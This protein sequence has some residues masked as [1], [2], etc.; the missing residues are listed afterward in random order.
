MSA[1]ISGQV[2]S[3]ALV[4]DAKCD[5]QLNVSLSIGYAGSAPTDP[6]LS[7]VA[8]VPLAVVLAAAVAQKGGVFGQAEAL[9]VQA[10]EAYLAAQPA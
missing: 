7:I 9:L 8:K 10:A 4:Y 1:E 5:N 6:S 2:G 3:S